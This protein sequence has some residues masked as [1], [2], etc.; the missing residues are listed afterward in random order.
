MFLRIRKVHLFPC[1]IFV[2]GDHQETDSISEGY[3]GHM[4]HKDDE[5]QALELCRK[6]DDHLYVGIADLCEQK[7]NSQLCGWA[8]EADTIY[9]NRFRR[10]HRRLQSLAA[11][12][13]LRKLSSLL[14][15]TTEL[16]M[17][18]PPNGPLMVSCDRPVWASISHCRSR[19]AV[20]LSDRFVVGI[21]IEEI[22]VTR[23]WRAIS[24]A[25]G[26]PLTDQHNPSYFYTRWCIR[27]CL[28][29]IGIETEWRQLIT[30]LNP[31]QYGV[32]GTVN[33]EPTKSAIRF[34]AIHSDNFVTVVTA[35][36]ISPTLN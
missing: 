16:T 1:S 11:R 14:F 23:D 33:L 9:A 29:K 34:D 26:F 4:T 6:V 2:I 30:S 5:V 35:M 8:T 12:G 17:S 22:N 21:D 24:A 31:D 25:L 13:L 28:I 32:K 3:E 15:Q 36:P 20:A 18:G 7:V 27:E 19:I 10:S